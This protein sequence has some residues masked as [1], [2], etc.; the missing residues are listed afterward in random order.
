MTCAMD[1]ETQ[2]DVSVNL[3]LNQ[4]TPDVTLAIGFSRRFR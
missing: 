3:G 2:L 1:S 4:H